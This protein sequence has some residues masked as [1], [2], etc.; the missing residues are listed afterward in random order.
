MG[1]AKLNIPMCAALVL[2]FLTLISIHMTSGLYARYVATASGSDSARV[3]KFD[4][5]TSLDNQDIV[6]DCTKATE[7]NKYVVTVENQSE[8]TVKYDLYITI[9][10]KAPQKNADGQIIQFNATDLTVSF[11]ETPDN[12]DT[13]AAADNIPDPS[14]PMKFTNKV[15]N[16]GHKMVYELKVEI[17]VR[18]NANGTTATSWNSITGKVNGEEFFNWDFDV[19]AEIQVTQVD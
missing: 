4:V 11:T 18:E 1:K 15:L 19:T 9:T 8:V 16:P 17:P 14:S 12:A 3:A 13:P 6:I 5:R 10:S 7:N 2:L